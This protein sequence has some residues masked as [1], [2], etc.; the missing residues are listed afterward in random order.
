M[1]LIKKLVVLKGHSYFSKKTNH[2]NSKIVMI[3]LRKGRSMKCFGTVD[4][5]FEICH[6]TQTV[7]KTVSSSLNRRQRYKNKPISFRLY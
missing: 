4:C 7:Q 2:K 3:L 6:K 5:F 1:L